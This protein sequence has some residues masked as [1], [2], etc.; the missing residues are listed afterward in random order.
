MG[1][2]NLHLHKDNELV[3]KISPETKIL[4]KKQQ[5]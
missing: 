3:L 4:S 5:P 1:E 2:T